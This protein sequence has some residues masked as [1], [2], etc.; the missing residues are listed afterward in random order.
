MTKIQIHCMERSIASKHRAHDRS[1]TPGLYDTDFPDGSA[2]F[3]PTSDQKALRW[4]DSLPNENWPK[5]SHMAPNVA[6]LR[7]LHRHLISLPLQDSPAYNEAVMS[8]TTD[9]RFRHGLEK[10]LPGWVREEGVVQSALRLLPLVDCLWIKAG[11]RGLLVVQ[12]CT[13]EELA[14]FESGSKDLPVVTA[15][16]SLGGIVISYHRALKLER[17]VSVVGGGDSLLGAL[18]AGLVSGLRS[19]RPA[20]LLRLVELGQRW[21]GSACGAPAGV[22]S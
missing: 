17:Q 9:E 18:L 2:I 6:E 14:G 16:G 13:K 22:A 1:A 12:K 4:L 10:R 5:L 20:D 11:G 7:S 3:E 15:S 19:A 21:A 8:W